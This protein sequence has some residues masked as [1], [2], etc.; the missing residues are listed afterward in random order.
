VSPKALIVGASGQVG[1][2]LI[3]ELE[4]RAWNWEG[5]YFEHSLEDSRL[6]KLDLADAEG[7][8]RE[9][10]R[11][12][13]QA[14][15]LP[16]GWTWVDG[17]ED[18]PIRAYQINAAAPGAAAEAAALL[19]IPL[20]YYS[21]E[22][23][24]GEQGGPYDE[25]RAVNP[26]GIYGASKWE[27]ERRV[28]LAWPQAL[29]LRTTVVYGPEPQGK[30]FVYQLRRQLQEGKA[31]RVPKDQISSPTYNG[32]LAKASLDLVEKGLGGLFNVAGPSYVDRY[33]FAL[34]VARVFNLDGSLI[35]G[36]PTALLK[37]KARRPLGAGLKIG[38]LVRALGW[39]P[40]GPEAGLEDMREALEPVHGH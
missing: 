14:V 17:C 4:A 13:P 23:V 40:R 18:D 3:R 28:R 15:F 36:V 20:V 12:A 37:Q 33:Q 10:M 25:L 30:N 32:D 7:L 31:V 19:Q 24:F 35:E 5:S 27:G 2:A 26:I 6:F 11:R 38:R 8:K 16:S 1:Q 22:Y 21:T 39:S 34:Q 9:I 29:I